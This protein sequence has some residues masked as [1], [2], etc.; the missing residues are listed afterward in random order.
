MQ[1]NDGRLYVIGGG[2]RTGKTAWTAE[3]VK[4]SRRVIAYD[5]DEQWC[6]L[7]GWRR[8][9]SH[10]E[11]IAACSEKGPAKLAFVPGGDLAKSFQFFCQC[12]LRWG[13]DFGPCDIVAEE[14]ADVTSSSKAPGKWG[15][16]LRR[17]L[18]RGI[19]IYAI[20]QRW[21]EADKTAMGNC[22]M[23]VCFMMASGD[24]I[25]YMA[26]KTR[27]PIPELEALKPLEYVTYD[28]GTKIISRSRLKFSR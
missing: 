7:P 15:L 27:I 18:K 10:A 9:E 19:S 21:A 23:F 13:R 25:T 17:G 12:A 14:L 2:S 6:A 24:D 28:T 22:S 8:I 1:T 20:S 4:K 11:L 26:R 3:Q 5:P 16:L